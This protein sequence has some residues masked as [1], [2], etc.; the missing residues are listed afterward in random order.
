MRRLIQATDA[1]ILARV[2]RRRALNGRVAREEQQARRKALRRYIR[3]RCEELG[4]DVA[5]LNDDT[6]REA[7]TRALAQGF[8]YAPAAEDAAIIGALR[9]QS[10]EALSDSIKSERWATGDCQCVVERIYH[11]DTPGESQT[12]HA[13]PCAAHAGMALD[14]LHDTLEDETQRRARVHRYL[15]E[16]HSDVLCAV[17]PDGEIIER[18]G[19]ISFTWEGQR[20][21]RVL[22]VQLGAGLL[23]AEQR[24]ALVAFADTT[25]GRKQIDGV[26]ASLVKVT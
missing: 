19:A 26:E 3:S 21:K 6:S 12:F 25:F 5:L 17:G 24:Q 4:I 10:S 23:D 20:R 14:A 8:T 9:A 7:L 15:H 13:I 22:V 16:H 2:A 11:R 1:E 18:P